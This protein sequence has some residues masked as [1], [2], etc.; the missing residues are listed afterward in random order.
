MN[1]D[2]LHFQPTPENIS[3][4]LFISKNRY[5]QIKPSYV[6]LPREILVDKKET[7]L[8][9]YFKYHINESSSY[10]D[11]NFD[12]GIKI[13]FASATRKIL[14]VSILLSQYVD[15]D[16][17]VRDLTS[18]LEQLKENEQ[19]ESIQIN[20]SVVSS[21]INWFMSEGHINQ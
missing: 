8:Q 2:I 17:K 13:E 9:F 6:L 4:N 15:L 12:N 21:F 18:L 7:S 10:F 14:S 11:E 3:N 1:N 16:D 20:Y 19:K 5:E